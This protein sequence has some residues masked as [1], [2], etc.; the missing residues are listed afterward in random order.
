MPFCREEAKTLIPNICFLAVPDCFGIEVG[1]KSTKKAKRV[2]S[3]IVLPQLVER[4]QSLVEWTLPSP[5][6]PETAAGA[7]LALPDLGIMAAYV[8]RRP[9]TLW[10][11]FC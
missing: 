2:N 4:Q 11:R 9:I 7:W 10:S 8:G 6:V 5:L 3:T 1:L